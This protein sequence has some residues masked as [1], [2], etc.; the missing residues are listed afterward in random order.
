MKIL[1]QE[2]YEKA[3]AYE[4]EIKNETL[5]KCIDSLKQ[6]EE[7]PNCHCEIDLYYDYEP[8]TLG[9][10]QVYPDGITGIVGGLL[11]NGQPDQ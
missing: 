2:S 3:V 6:W 7:N 10:R 8:H 4:K 1:C 5:K 9:F 11:Y